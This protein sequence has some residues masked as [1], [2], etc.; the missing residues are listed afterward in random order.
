MNVLTGYKNCWNQQGTAITRF[1]RQFEVN[2]VEKSLLWS[3][4]KSE[5][6]LLKR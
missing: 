1:L 4:V 6:C 2:W 3:D 5:D